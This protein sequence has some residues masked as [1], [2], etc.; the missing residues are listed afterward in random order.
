[1]MEP[2]NRVVQVSL[3]GD[4]ERLEVVDAP[5]PT[6]SRGEL[7]V[8]VLAS[9]LNYTEVLIR[10]HLYP[11][12]M[13]LRPP[14]VMGYDVV[15]AIDQLGEG[16]HDFQIGDRVADMTVVGSNADYRTL[17]A[18]DVA[19]VPEGVDAAE[20]ATLILS[21]TTAYQL[22]HRAARVER[23][24]RV[25]VHGAAGA[26]GQAL[27]VLGRLAGIELWGTARGEHMAL[28]R[29][30][31]A[32]PINYKHEDFTRVLPGGF[33]VIVDGVGEDGYRRSYA[34]LKPGGLLCAIGFSASVQAQRRM[35]PIV[36]EIARLYLWR[37]LP[38][39]KRARFYSVN[40]MRAR[41]PTWFKEDLER[42][43]GL[44]ATGAIRP[45]IAARIS[46]DEVADAHRRLETGGLEGKL[47][48][49]P[50]LSSRRNQRAA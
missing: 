11:Q 17:R 7:R 44:L 41:H 12:T 27:L 31:G 20:A 42:L 28:V 4:P 8:R 5:L 10:R 6:A 30:L 36:M 33:D 16:V 26:V 35:L 19:R 18:N 22:L 45:R 23:G 24:Q 21:W 49:C 47:V 15:G 2:R 38:G 40:A 29:E 43:F 9:S 13:G 46:F 48:L 50:D 25:L 34:A 14:F 37:L 39:G 3:F 1:M 32:T